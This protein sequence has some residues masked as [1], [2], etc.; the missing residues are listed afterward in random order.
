MT[1]RSVFQSPVVSALVCAFL[2][3]LVLPGVASA[4]GPH[5]IGA[6]T[7]IPLTVDL[8]K[9]AV[10]SWSEY[11]IADGQNNMSVRMALVTRSRGSADIETQIKG[12]PVAAL[13]HTTM[14]MSVPLDAAPEVKPSEQVI[15]LGDNPPMLLPVDLGGAHPQSFRKLDPKKRVGVDSI[16]VPGGAFP[17]A[18]HYQEKGSGGETVDFWVSKEILPFGL[19]KITSSAGAGSAVVMELVSHGGGAKPI[20]TKPPQPFDAATIMKQVQPA[21]AGAGVAGHSGPP[22]QTVPSPHPGMP[23]T[24]VGPPATPTSPAS[25]RK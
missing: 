11:H 6:S 9:V 1:C 10:G 17:R 19:I 24:P 13:G 7:P 20:I 21:T 4:Q 25:G 23:P 3:A 14:R 5:A 16:K 12:G 22:V 18:E 15:Q 8:K 2:N